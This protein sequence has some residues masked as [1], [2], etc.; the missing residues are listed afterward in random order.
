MAA[1]TPQ[2]IAR[3]YLLATVGDFARWR[4][5]T[6]QAAHLQTRKL[7][8]PEPLQHISGGKVP[9]WSAHAAATAYLSANMT[10]PHLP[11]QVLKYGARN[12]P[13][14]CGVA[15]IAHMTNTGNSGAARITLNAWFPPPIDYISTQGVFPVWDEALARTALHQ[16]GYRLTPQGPGP[17][18]AQGPLPPRHR[19]GTVRGAA[20]RNA[21]NGALNSG[22]PG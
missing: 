16:H 8:F 21:L 9:V 7:W 13:A 5:V 11:E 4:A 10:L 20:R 6:R 17:A 14:L 12:F 19:G 2:V 15:E 22:I 18:P 1:T 3:S